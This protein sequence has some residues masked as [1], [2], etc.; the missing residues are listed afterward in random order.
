MLSQ[1]G[2]GGSFTIMSQPTSG[3]YKITEVNEPSDSDGDGVLDDQDA[4]PNSAPS[5]TVVINGCDS[6]VENKLLDDGCTIADL[7]QGALATG[8][9]DDDLED[10]LEDL[11]DQDILTEDE[12]EAIEDCEEDDEEDD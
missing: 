3:T 9:D 12:A 10:L 11:E 8:D 6:G 2:L 1:A 7:V 4:C 5:P